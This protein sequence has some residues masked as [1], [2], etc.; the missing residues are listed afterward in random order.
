[1]SSYISRNYKDYTLPENT[2]GYYDWFY[3]NSW[4]DYRPFIKKITIKDGITE[5]GDCNFYGCYNATEVDIASSVTSIGD[6]AFQ[7]CTSLESVVI[8]AGV[9][10]IGNNCF[11][12]C[13][14]LKNLE[15]GE[16]VETIGNSAFSNLKSLKNLTFNACNAVVSGWYYANLFANAGTESEGIKVVFGDSVEAI[17]NRFF[18]IGSETASPNIREIV[19]GANVSR[20][21]ERAFDGCGTLTEFTI[22]STVEVIGSGAFANCTGLNEIV[23]PENVDY[24]GENA[25]TGCDRLKTIRYNSVNADCAYAFDRCAFADNVYIGE[26]VQKLCA[27]A[28]TGCT[29]LKYAYIPDIVI[30]I[31]PLAFYSCGDVAI[32]CKDGSYAN[33]YAAVNGLKYM[34]SNSEGTVFEIKNNVL[35]SYSGSARNVVVPSEITAIGINAF[36]GTD[37]TCVELPYSVNKIYSGAFSNCI[38]LEKVIV[39]YTVTSIADNAFAGSHAAICCYYGSYA[40]KYAQDKGIPVEIITV[41]FGANKLSLYKGQ[42]KTIDYEPSVILACGLPVTFSSDNAATAAVDE[43]GNVTGTA[44]GQANI[45]AYTQAG[46]RLGS[47]TVSVSG[48]EPKIGI[49]KHQNKIDV[50]YWST[51]ILHADAVLP[52]GAK[53][54][55]YN[56]SDK[57]LTE[58]KDY[59]VTNAENSYTV[60]AAIVDGESGEIIA[61]TPAETVNVKSGIFQKLIAFI[62]NLFKKLPVVDQK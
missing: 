5:I 58:G 36:A 55:W 4:Y 10:H 41:N 30:D 62:R 28:F 54:K 31:D 18:S 44:Q 25:F 50:S 35:I 12:N 7:Q 24:I 27:Y 42:K 20:I 43:S 53:I 23:I 9:T 29:H 52:D 2:T 8:P 48:I 45:T 19:F 37:V 59:K 40:A 61:R 17:P 49:V 38:S 32:V 56:D 21:G 60:Y 26:N 1:M 3:N 46:N 51:V 22:P 34:L 33:A 47:I 13:Y 15:I 6:R 11:S 57:F 39:P 16:N 14:S